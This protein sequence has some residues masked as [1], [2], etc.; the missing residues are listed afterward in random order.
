MRPP[1]EDLEARRA[2]WDALSRLFL[3]TDVSLDRTHRARV[4]ASSPYSMTEIEEILASEVFPVCVWNFSSIAPEWAGF[5]ADS[6]ERRITHLGQK[7][8]RWR[9]SLGRCMIFMSRE[10]RLTRNEVVSIRGKDAA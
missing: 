2:V 9:T 4:L 10:W 1:H 5:N 6:L 7:S 3:D 8:F